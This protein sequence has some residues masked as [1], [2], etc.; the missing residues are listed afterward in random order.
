MTTT[1]LPT[2]ER[3]TVSLPATHRIA[4]ALA[5]AVA[6][7]IAALVAGPWVLAAWLLPDVALIAGFAA[8]GRLK[9]SRVRAYNAAHALPGPI[10]LTALGVATG[11]LALG[12]GLVW[13]SHVAVDRAFGYGLRGRDGW[14]RG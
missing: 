8:P 2:T 9:P 5:G 4:L 1:S 11:G 14:Q 13:L 12:L 7:T 6:A 10:A 3:P